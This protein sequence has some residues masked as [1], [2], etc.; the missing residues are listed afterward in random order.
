[1]DIL[2]A[3][4]KAAAQA[5]ARQQANLVEAV[6]EPRQVVVHE[7]PGEQEEPFDPVATAAP[8]PGPE[9]P[10]PVAPVADAKADAGS[11][12]EAGDA[13][14]AEV[15]A[16]VVQQELEL[17]SFRLGGE[18]YAVLVEDVRE[19]LKVFQL[20]QVP[21]SAEYI[22]GVMSLR[23]TVLPVI[24]LGMRLGI[25]PAL[26]DEKARIIVVSPDDG[27]GD[28]GLLVDRVTGVFRILPDEVKPAPEHIEQGAEYLRGIARKGD[29]LYIL[30][31]LEKVVNI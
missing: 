31:D 1:M 22:L 20:T 17:L 6:P 2:A 29:R 21:N 19:V 25:A 18:E 11:M 5:K 16:E 26:R 30:L 27:D 7:S 4:K 12:H 3:R 14:S 9:M 8:A 24:D 13:P 15:P 10:A 23:G 28:S